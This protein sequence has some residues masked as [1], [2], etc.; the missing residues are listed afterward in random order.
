[1]VNNSDISCDM[2]AHRIGSLLIVFAGAVTALAGMA[3]VTIA[4]M[5]RARAARRPRPSFDL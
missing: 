3:I 2:D 1:M 5:V 4:V